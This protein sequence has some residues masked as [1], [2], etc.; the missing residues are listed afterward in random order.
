MCGIAGWLSWNEPVRVEY[1]EAMTREI[2][3]R[4]PDAHGVEVIG[5]A[6]LGHR[7]LSIIDT[8]TINNQPL[9][10]T[11]GKFWIAFNGEIY[12]FQEIRSSL[13]R[14][15]VQFQT[16]GDTEV[17]LE[18]YKAYGVD[19]LAQFNGMFAFAIWDTVRELLFIAR[20]RA[21]E[22]P[23][24]YYTF[25]DGSMLWAS[26]PNALLKHPEVG[27][28]LNPAALAQYLS[29]TYTVGEDYLVRGLKRLAPGSYLVAQRGRQP[30]TRSYWNFASAFQN[31]RT[32]IT[33]KDAAE[34]LNSLLSEAVSMRM[35]SDV[36]LGAFL[37]VVNDTSC[38]DLDMTLYA[39]RQS[40]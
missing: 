5:P 4:G 21:G 31:K 40:K 35:I 17:I 34:E 33:E 29:L 27:T 28:G 7:R 2:A 14:N 1:L 15:G 26:E 18:A 8:S 30:E 25:P 24:F 10:D 32:G 20:D 38:Y 37:R 22:K 39:P 16:K 23:L 19:C 13:E 6:G 36:P 3:H 11:T 12:N 9:C